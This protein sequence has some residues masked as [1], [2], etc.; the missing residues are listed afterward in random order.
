MLHSLG[1]SLQTPALSEYPLYFHSSFY[2]T[3]EAPVSYWCIQTEPICRFQ[4][5]CVILCYRSVADFVAVGFG[6]LL[7]VEASIRSFDSYT[8]TS[9]SHEHIWVWS[10]FHQITT[11]VSSSPM[12]LS[13]LEVRGRG[14]WPAG[15]APSEFERLMDV[16]ICLWSSPCKECP[17]SVLSLSAP[18]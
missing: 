14:R 9:V 11:V 16:C 13:F 2:P 10:V 8:K 3:W 5:S 6:Y 17:Y 4:E 18:S 12:W 7:M 1:F 15:N